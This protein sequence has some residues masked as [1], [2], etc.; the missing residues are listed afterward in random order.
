MKFTMRGIYDTRVFGAI[1]PFLEAKTLE[2]IL[3][4]NTAVC[5]AGAHRRT[6]MLTRLLQRGLYLGPESELM[7]AQINN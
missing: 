1:C 5:I 3:I 4:A 6:S 2:G 7:P